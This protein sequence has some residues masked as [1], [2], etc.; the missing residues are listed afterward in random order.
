MH[1]AERATGKDIILD[2][3]EN[4]RAYQEELLY[5]SIVPTA[6]E[7]HLHPDDYDRLEGIFPA[8]ATE[9]RRA[10]DEE[11]ARQNRRRGPEWLRKLTKPSGPAQPAH[12]GWIV[13]FC[14]DENEELQPGE[15]VVD[16]RL[17]LPEAPELGA[18]TRTRRITTS[19]L[20][21]QTSTRSQVVDE[22]LPA[23]TA[24][25]PPP[26]PAM[27]APTA[28]IP[29]PAPTPVT[30]ALAASGATARTVPAMAAGQ[31]DLPAAA[32]VVTPTAVFAT[33]TFE[34]NSGRRTHSITQSQVV[35]G[36]GGAGYWVDLRVDAAPD[37]SREHVRLRRDV[38]TGQFFLKDLSLYGTTVNGERVASSIDTSE[39]DKRDVNIEVPLPPVARI[40]LAD[41]VFLDFRVAGGA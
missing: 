28:P 9:A 6:F 11:L 30:T 39:G 1:A 37:V 21:Q 31:D 16:S 23:S 15:V 7:V 41:M 24:A 13:A 2:I 22:P 36:R 26:I 5:T 19:R 29:V 14:R 10:L 12:D 32:S 33:L 27:A 3:V 4:M 40:G 38:S 8:I 17:T 18:G 34:D 35:I 25:V 20:G